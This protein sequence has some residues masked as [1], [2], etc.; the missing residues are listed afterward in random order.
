MAELPY[1]KCYCTNLRR[2]ANT[3][4]EFYNAALMETGLTAA[5]YYLLVNLMRLEKANITHWAERVGLD[6]STMV[7]NIRLLEARDLIRKTEGSGKTFTLSNQGR[8]VLDRA[9]PIWEEAQRKIQCFL[10]EEDSEALLRIG[11]KLQALNH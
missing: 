7:R 11:S 6:R 8:A 9:I 3:V 10:G 2:S 5:Q 4:S 1:S